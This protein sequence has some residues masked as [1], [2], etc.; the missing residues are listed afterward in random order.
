MQP[1]FGGRRHLVAAGAVVIGS[2]SDSTLVL[3]APGVSPRH[4]VIRPLGSGTAVMV[5]ALPGAEILVNGARHG[6]IIPVGGCAPRAVLGIGASRLLF[7]AYFL[8][9]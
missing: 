1:E 6:D 7:P 2:G 4:A 3:A 8:L 9:G 5:P